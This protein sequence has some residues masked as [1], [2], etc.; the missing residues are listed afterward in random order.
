MPPHNALATPP[1]LLPRQ[2]VR[3]PV[4]PDQ[5]CQPVLVNACLAG[6]QLLVQ[7]EV[8]VVNQDERQALDQEARVDRLAEPGPSVHDPREA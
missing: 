4:I 1:G 5:V 3:R 6:Y 7:L 2:P 8:V